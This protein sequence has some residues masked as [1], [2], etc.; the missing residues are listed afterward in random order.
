MPEVFTMALAD[1]LGWLSYFTLP[2]GRAT[3]I[4][5]ATKKILAETGNG[6]MVCLSPQKLAG[7]AVFVSGWRACLVEPG[8]HSRLFVTTYIL[9]TL[10]DWAFL[11]AGEGFGRVQMYSWCSETASLK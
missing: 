2:V 9:L 5:A 1:T 4:F 8:T 11:S 6:Q 10:S 7:S 3:A